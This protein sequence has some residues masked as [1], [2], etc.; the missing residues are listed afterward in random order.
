MIRILFLLLI[1]GSVVARAS[2]PISAPAR[3]ASATISQPHVTAELISSIYQQHPLKPFDI[4]LHLHMEPGWHTYWINPGDAGLATTITWTLPPGF[5]AGPIQWPTPE[6]HPMGPLMTYGYAGDVYLITRITVPASMRSIDVRA[7]APVFQFTAHAS[8]LVCKEE[9]CIPGKADLTLPMDFR[10]VH[11]ETPDDALRPHLFNE[12]YARLPAPNTIYDVDGFYGPKGL[13]L[14]FDRHDDAY[15]ASTVNGYFFPEQANV[16]DPKENT[17][18]IDFISANPSFGIS[19]PLQQNGEK[20]DSL[21]GVLV[22]D[23]PIIGKSNAIYISKF[24]VD[25]AP[26][27]ETL[28]IVPNPAG[29]PI[30]PA[31]GPARPTN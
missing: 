3:G 1:A 4:I 24:H 11:I 12:A 29:P 2:D 13:L 15:V 22:S 14:D 23:T 30:A 6:K 16:L 7:P 21:S 10:Q 17:A 5:T 18:G 25:P 8:W 28:T 9:E 27:S 20:P 26:P 31:Q 19:L